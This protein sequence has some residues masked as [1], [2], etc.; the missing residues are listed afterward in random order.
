[1]NL[2]HSFG[3]FSVRAQDVARFLN[4]ANLLT[5]NISVV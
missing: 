1:M 3:D 5:A 2:F 4:E